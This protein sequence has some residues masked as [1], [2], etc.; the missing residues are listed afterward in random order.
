MLENPLQNK[1]IRSHVNDSFFQKRKSYHAFWMK[2]RYI[3]MKDFQEEC[4]IGVLW[5]LEGFPSPRIG[6]RMVTTGKLKYILKK[7]NWNINLNK[8]E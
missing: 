2:E 8:L 7:K 5:L 4:A 6:R 1:K 3:R